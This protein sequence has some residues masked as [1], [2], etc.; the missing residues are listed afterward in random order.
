[1]ERPQFQAKLHGWSET[2]S[3]YDGKEDKK[4]AFYSLLMQK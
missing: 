3:Q 4:Q 2:A 1:M